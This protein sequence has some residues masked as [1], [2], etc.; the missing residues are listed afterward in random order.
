VDPLALVVSGAL[1]VIALALAWPVPVVFARADWPTHAPARALLLWQAIALAGGLSMIGA[2]VAL[3]LG[4]VG[5]HPV[6]GGVA[7]GAALGFALHLLGHLAATVVSVARQRRRHHALLELLSSPHPTR[8]RTRVLDDGAPV[9]Y[10][11]PHGIGSL[12][13][14]SRGLLESLGPAELAAVIAHERAHVEQRHDLLLVAFRAWRSALPWFPIA[15]R[16]EQEVTVLVELL[17]DDRARREAPD[18]VLARAILAVAERRPD[19]REAPD[20]SRRASERVR[21]LVPETRAH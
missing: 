15:A 20:P 16:A 1:A 11:L 21:R 17:A 19:A 8:A 9:A 13:V 14:L 5:L 18:A 7:Y 4:L 12:T 2:L 6:W 10:C 3:G